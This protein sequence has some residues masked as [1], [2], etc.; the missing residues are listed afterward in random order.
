MIVLLKSL[1]QPH[2]DYCSQLWCP[3]SQG[4]INKL[5]SVQRSLVN[6]I[7][8][9]RLE[10]GNYW[11][12]LHSLRLYSPFYSIEINLSKVLTFIFSSI[13]KRHHQAK[14][15][16]EGRR[17]WGIGGKFLL[18]FQYP[19]WASSGGKFLLIFQHPSWASSGGKFLPTTWR[20]ACAGANIEPKYLL[21]GKKYCRAF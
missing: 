16:H 21:I 13:E 2:L 18:I 8:D 11:D 1:V 17:P 20:S 5:E 12:K 4:L 10:N 19:S 14:D 15:M 6:K 7:W 9:K 3:S